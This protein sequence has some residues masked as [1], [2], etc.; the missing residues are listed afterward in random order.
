MNL[1][2]EKAILPQQEQDR[3]AN[4]LL[5]VVH[6][7]DMPSSTEEEEWDKLINSPE[8]IKWLDSEI[9]DI[10]REIEKGKALNFDPSDLFK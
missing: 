5:K 1:L 2:L 7:I 9:D 8:S 4:A 3:L 10:D 6:G